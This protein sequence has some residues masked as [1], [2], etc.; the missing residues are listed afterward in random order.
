M[1]KSSIG[2]LGAAA[3]AFVANAVCAQGGVGDVVYVPTPQVVVDT[4]LT[5][6]KVGLRRVGEPRCRK[7]GS[8]ARG[9]W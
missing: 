4:M 7:H 8:A 5:M 9:T 3:L 1:L 2:S 6:A